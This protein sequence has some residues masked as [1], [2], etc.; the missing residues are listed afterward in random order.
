M[1][2]QHAGA[3]VHK[4]LCQTLVQRV[5]QPVLNVTG[6]FAPMRWVFKPVFPI[7]DVSPGADL[8]DPITE[9]VDIADGVVAETHLLGNPIRRNRA[10]TAKVR[11]DARNDL[12]MLGRRDVAIVGQ[13]A[14]LPHELDIGAADGQLARFVAR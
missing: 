7:G 4:T 5:A 14:A 13:G 2:H 9:G 1:T 12:A 8:A 11:I 3:P 10:M 6:L